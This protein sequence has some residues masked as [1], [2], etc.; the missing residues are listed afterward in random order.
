LPCVNKF[1][2]EKI[3]SENIFDVPTQWLTVRYCARRC[4]CIGVMRAAVACAAEFA[5]TIT[6]TT[7]APA[8]RVIDKHGKWELRG[9]KRRESAGRVLTTMTFLVLGLLNH[10]TP[11]FICDIFGMNVVCWLSDMPSWLSW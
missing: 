2:T 7:I 9:N 4:G 1:R 10:K 5:T 8:E 11:N 3:T 6:A